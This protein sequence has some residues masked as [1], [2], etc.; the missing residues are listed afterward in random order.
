MKIHVALQND[1]VKAEMNTPGDF[2]SGMPRKQE[3][4]AVRGCTKHPN[5]LYDG[6]YAPNQE[7]RGTSLVRSRHHK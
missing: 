5:S 7:I 2:I 3:K 1:S 4:N 6:Q